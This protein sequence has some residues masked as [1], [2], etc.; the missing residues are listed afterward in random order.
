M[1]SR[2]YTPKKNF[3]SAPNKLL[4]RYFNKKNVL[5]D[6]DFKSFS[7]T[8]INHIYDAWLELPDNIQAEM[9]RDFREIYALSTEGGI[10]AII[11]EALFHEEKL[12]EKFEDMTS[13][14][15][16]SFWTFLENKKFLEGALNFFHADTIPNNY[17]L[18]NKNLP[19]KKRLHT[20]FTK[21]NR[22][23][24]WFSFKR[25]FFKNIKNQEDWPAVY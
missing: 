10:K 11:D 9:E 12:V 24:K 17:W 3:R 1:S 6:L 21:K 7:E 18:K 25:R 14:I 5:K 20:A 2:Q 15:D 8:N 22:R 16:R 19:R 4:K 23:N 13:P